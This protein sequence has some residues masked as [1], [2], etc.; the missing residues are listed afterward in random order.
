MAS[1]KDGGD[2]GRGKTGAEAFDM[3]VTSGVAKVLDETMNTAGH[4]SRTFEGKRL[5]D[6]LDTIAAAQ[7]RIKARMDEASESCQGDRQEIKES[8]KELVDSGYPSTELATLIRKHKLQRQIDNI[9]A[10]LDDEQ[11]ETFAAMV[12]ALGQLGDTA[13]GQAAIQRSGLELVQ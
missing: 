2:K 4:N 7:D 11:K 13:L 6:M 8:K 5:A 12:E 1:K 3:T 9:D 10:K